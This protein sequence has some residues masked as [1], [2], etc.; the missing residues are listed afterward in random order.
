MFRVG[1]GRS[2][3]TVRMLGCTYGAIFPYI[4]VFLALSVRMLKTECTYIYSCIFSRAAL[5]KA[6]PSP[7]LLG[8]R[9]RAAAQVLMERMPQDVIAVAVHCCSLWLPLV[10]YAPPSAHMTADDDAGCDRR[11]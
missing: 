3:F 8:L 9:K 11:G 2:A 6:G 4:C 5:L 7:W 1:R 10:G